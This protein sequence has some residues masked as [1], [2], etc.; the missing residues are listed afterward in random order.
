VMGA[1][2][3]APLD[4]LYFDLFKGVLSL[5]LLEMGLVASRQLDALR[6]FG[7]FLSVYA[8]VMQLVSATLGLGLG[9]ALGLSAGGLTLLATLAASASYIAAPAAM[10]VAVPDANPGLSIGAALGVTFPVNLVIGI[11]LYYQAASWLRG[12]GA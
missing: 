11:P 12:G 4:R 9:M 5:F 1:D 2:G 10:R 3:I 6:R 8:V 7:P